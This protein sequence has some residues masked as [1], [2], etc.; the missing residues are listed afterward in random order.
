[1]T[2][3]TR[4]DVGS[5]AAKRAGLV[6]RNWQRWGADDERGALNLLESSDVAS[7]ARL[8][9]RGEVFPLAREIGR[10][11][12]TPAIRPAPAHFMHRDGGDYSRARNAPPRAQF[13]DDS[14]LLA[15]HT[16]THIDALA[17]VWYGDEIFNGFAKETVTSRGAG[18]CGVEKLG[19]FA[20]RGVLL[21]VA[22]SLGIES[23]PEE[24]Q[25]TPEDLE[26]CL[27]VQGVSVRRADIVLIRTGWWSAYAGRQ[28]PAFE[29]EPGPNL[30]AACWLA[31]R[32]V[33]VVG[34]DNFAFEALPSEVD[35][36][37]F[38]VHELLLCDCGIPILE[39]LALDDLA[40]QRIYEF[41]FV[42]APLPI[43]GGTASP[44][45]PVAII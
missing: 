36:S 34:A 42:A 26:R 15:L 32:D 19:P 14:I 40:R 31:E 11:T 12:P 38:P 30:D 17:H 43:V 29:R 45:N 25:V 37:V 3:E 44:V 33:A 35:G 6:R 4:A 27:D 39:G 9:R 5:V 8:V 1:M 16:A 22:A 24:R 20:G 18:R 13:S 41:M 7:A 21:D 10:S 28:H 2:R 23:L